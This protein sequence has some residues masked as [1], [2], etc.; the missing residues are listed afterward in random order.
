MSR[1]AMKARPVSLRIRFFAASAI[2][3]TMASV[4]TYFSAGVLTA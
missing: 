2:T 4:N 3:D 1:T